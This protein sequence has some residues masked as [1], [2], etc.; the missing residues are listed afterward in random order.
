M[1]DWLLR[2]EMRNFVAGCIIHDGKVTRECAP[3]LRKW[4]GQ[5]GRALVKWC[6]SK[7]GSASWTD[8][9]SKVTPD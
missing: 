2:I 3:I 5:E 4:I 7:G 8:V 6:R 1:T 9:I